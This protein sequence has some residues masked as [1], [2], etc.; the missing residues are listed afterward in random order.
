VAASAAYLIFRTDGS[1]AWL[2]KMISLEKQMDGD[3]T[4]GTELLWSCA[5]SPGPL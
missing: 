5:A 1:G 2:E 3:A 4:W